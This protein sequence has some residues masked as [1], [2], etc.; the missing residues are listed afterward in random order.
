MKVDKFYKDSIILTISNLVTGIIG[1]TFSVI[2]SKKLGPEGLG[3][4][5][6][7]M[8]FYVLL[9]CLTSDGLITA[10]SRISAVYHSQRDYKNL[11]RTFSTITAFIF[12]WSFAIAVFIFINSSN[13]VAHIFRDDRVGFAIKIICPALVFIPLGA[14]LKGFFYGTDRYKVAAFID[15]VE[16]LLRIAFFLMIIRV[17]ALQDIK[18]TVSAAY[19]ALM[20]GELF[21]FLFLFLAFRRYRNRGVSVSHKPQRRFQLL[22]NVLVISLPLCL[23]GFISSLLSTASTLLLPRRLIHAG[24]QYE[25][26]LALIGK[27]SGMAL[28]ITFLPLIIVGSMMTVLIPDLSVSLNK[29]DSWAAESRIYQVLRISYLVGIS[30]LVVSMTIPDALGILFY[31]RNDLGDY[32]RFAA[33]AGFLSFIALPTYGILNGLGMQN[34]NLKNS[35]IVSVLSLILV[36]LLT[37]IPALNIYGYGTA[38]ALTSAAAL[39]LNLR[40]IRKA[41]DI[42]FPLSEI[43]TYGV[44]GLIS[45]F[46][47]RLL[48]TLI[49]DSLLMIR[50]VITVLLGFFLVFYLSDLTQ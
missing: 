9:I 17:L 18:S 43:I 13:I 4:Y 35:I 44:I 47:L 36:Y 45:F 28:N 41:C 38:M 14:I 19:F 5:G 26:A 27:F 32:I 7:I 23:N 21:S 37:G 3:L 25:A 20:A 12:L 24:M 22:S 46:T 15:V 40:H 11:N 31:G 50:T 39:V 16:K 30:T 8:P 42:R 33:M 6:L 48:N 1:F 49:P 34:I 29:K 10:V 2:L